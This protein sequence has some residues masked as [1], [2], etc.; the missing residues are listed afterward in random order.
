MKGDTKHNGC[1]VMLSAMYAKCHYAKCH[2]A[3]CHYADFHCVLITEKKLCSK[4][5][6]FSQ[7]HALNV[8]KNNRQSRNLSKLL[9]LLNNLS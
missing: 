8:G 7:I 1:I 3:K 4:F 6:N 5:M 2:Y 9:S